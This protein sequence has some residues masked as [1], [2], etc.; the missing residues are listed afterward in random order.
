MGGLAGG[1]AK[2]GKGAQGGPGRIFWTWIRGRG[3]RTRNRGVGAWRAKGLAGRRKYTLQL[4]SPDS[5][6]A[7]GGGQTSMVD[8]GEV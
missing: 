7:N 2:T 8:T 3:S 4:E 5:F 6:G 1:E